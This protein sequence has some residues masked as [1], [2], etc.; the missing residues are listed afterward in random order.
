MYLDVHIGLWSTVSAVLMM[1]NILVSAADSITSV[2]RK[3]EV[4][5]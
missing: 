2:L 1:L 5:F 4:S 3:F